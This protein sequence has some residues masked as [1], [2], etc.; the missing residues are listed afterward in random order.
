MSH[1]HPVEQQDLE[2]VEL[3]LTLTA[4]VFPS[5]V[6]LQVTLQVPST[7]RI[8][9]S[10]V[11]TSTAYGD[12]VMS[13]T[14]PPIGQ[15]L[16]KYWLLREGETWAFKVHTFSRLVY[17]NKTTPFLFFRDLQEFKPLFRPSTHHHQQTSSPLTRSSLLGGRMRSS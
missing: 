6:T 14:Y 13:N 16:E 8:I 17:Y 9:S 2:I 11:L 12:V 7:R 10:R 4:I 15:T 5:E 3:V 1:P